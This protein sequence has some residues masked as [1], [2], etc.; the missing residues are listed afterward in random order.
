M[1]QILLHSITVEFISLSLDHQYSI[2]AIIET[3]TVKQNDSAS[4]F[5]IL[6]S[7]TERFNH[8]L[9]EY[10][11]FQ[12]RWDGYDSVAFKASTIDRV[13]TAAQLAVN[14]FRVVGKQPLKIITGPASDGSVDLEVVAENKTLRLTFDPD[15]DDVNTYKE[16][17]VSTSE[18]PFPLSWAHLESEL[19]WLVS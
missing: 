16:D 12:P 3:L 7:M 2:N 13:R 10:L 19:R 14:F 8:D 4:L 17:A 11:Q 15:S 6:D 18:T 1:Q 9:N 5:S